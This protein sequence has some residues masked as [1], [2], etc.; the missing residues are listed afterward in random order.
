MTSSGSPKRPLHRKRHVSKRHK[1]VVMPNILFMKDWKC[2]TMDILSHTI[3]LI[4]VPS[5]PDMIDNHTFHY[6]QIKV[7][8]VIPAIDIVKIYMIYENNQTSQQRQQ[9]QDEKS[10]ASTNKKRKYYTLTNVTSTKITLCASHHPE[11]PNFP[12]KRNHNVD[13]T[14]HQ[15]SKQLRFFP[16]PAYKVKV[17][18]SRLNDVVEPNSRKRSRITHNSTI[19]SVLAGDFTHHSISSIDIPP[20]PPTQRKPRQ[21]HCLTAQGLLLYVSKKPAT[22]NDGNNIIHPITKYL[23]DVLFPLMTIHAQTLLID[24]NPD[25]KVYPPSP[26]LSYLSSKLASVTKLTQSS[27]TSSSTLQELSGPIS[28]KSPRLPDSPGSSSS[29]SVESKTLPRLIPHFE[30]I[31]GAT[32]RGNKKPIHLSAATR[33]LFTNPTSLLAPVISTSSTPVNHTITPSLTTC[34][35]ASNSNRPSLSIIEG[36]KI[37]ISFKIKH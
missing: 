29:S 12:M 35:T 1:T 20:K 33:D 23:V 2:N 14:K 34:P 7:S 37:I 27:T 9:Q 13:I 6:G 8:W 10:D 22:V 25:E 21:L 17:Y 4:L 24:D 28:R 32:S 36:A 3:R 30:N 5:H 26:S 15:I 19:A 31:Y 18:L 16:S 11:T